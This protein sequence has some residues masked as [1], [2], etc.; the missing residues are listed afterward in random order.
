[1]TGSMTGLIISAMI[2]SRRA[3]SS[4]MIYVGTKRRR[5]L[6]DTWT[7]P[8]DSSSGSSK[9]GDGR[10][11]YRASLLTRSRIPAASLV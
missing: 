9:A 1:M 10:L 11:R 8:L 4:E 6:S 5:G 7:D 3:T 2:G